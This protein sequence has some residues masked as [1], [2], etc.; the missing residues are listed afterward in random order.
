[1]RLRQRSRGVH[2]SGRCDDTTVSQSQ[3]RLPAQELG[4]WR[5]RPLSGHLEHSNHEASNFSKL[6]FKFVKC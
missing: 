1:M 4:P 6:P 3:Q 5:A 2:R